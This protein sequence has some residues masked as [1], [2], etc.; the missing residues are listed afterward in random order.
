MCARRLALRSQWAD[1][2]DAV[3]LHLDPRWRNADG[4]WNPDVDGVVVTYQQVASAPDLFA[5][6]LSRPTFVVLDEVHHAGDSA[7]WG[8]ALRA[9]FDRA[10]RRFRCL[11]R[12]FGRTRGRSRSSDMTRIAAARLISSTAMARPSR[13]R[14]AARWRFV[15][16]MRHCVGGWT[17][18]SGSQHSPTSSSRSMTPGGCGRRS[19]QRRRCCPR[20]CAMQTRCC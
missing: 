7:T 20:C 15:C 10:E 8:T 6:H 5:H 18:R 17:R 14:S 11:A 19:I 1:A 13:M 3:G 16:S 12:R 9:A 2:A 4:A